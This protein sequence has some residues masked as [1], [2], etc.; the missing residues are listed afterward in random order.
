MT[1]GDQGGQKIRKFADVTYGSLGC[2]DAD[3]D[4]RR[5][6]AG[7]EAGRPR[8]F[9]LTQE[10]GMKDLAIWKGSRSALV[11]SRNTQCPKFRPMPVP[12][13]YSP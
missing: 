6:A 12:T 8:S 3:A 13:Q 9:L 7:E 10:F 2:E 5:A 4:E 11:S 1:R